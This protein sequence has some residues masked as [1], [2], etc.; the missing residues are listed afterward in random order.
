MYVQRAP[1]TLLLLQAFLR[2]PSEWRYGYDLSRDTGIRHGTLYPQL[3]RLEAS[4]ILQS[5]WQL[6]NGGRGKR[7][8][9]YRLTD[10][11]REEAKAM[12]A[13]QSAG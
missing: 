9:M 7:R 12:L 3:M 1:Q 8:H 13:D 4:G 10:T 6:E 5:Y 2:R 11:G